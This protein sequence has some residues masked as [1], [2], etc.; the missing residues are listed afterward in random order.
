ML[1]AISLRARRPLW[2]AG[3][4]LL[5]LLLLTWAARG[6]WTQQAE[7][8]AAAQ[9]EAAA[10]EAMAY[11]HG[12]FERVQNALLVEAQAL[13]EDSAV[14]GGLRA[15]AAGNSVP[16]TLVRRAAT[17]PLL[18]RMAVEVYT[19]APQLVAWNGFSMPPDHAPDAPQFIKEPQTTI[20]RDGDV[21]L[22][23]V[24]WWP[25]RD[26][27]RTVGAVR[28][29]RLIR[30]RTSIQNQYLQDYRLADEWAQTTGLPVEMSLWAD[31]AAQLPNSAA[32]GTEA[33][34]ALRRVQLLEGVGGR[35]LGRLSVTA[36][37]TQQIV[38]QGRLWFS[39]LMALWATGGLVL[40]VV[41][42]WRRYRA[43]ERVPAAVPTDTSVHAHLRRAAVVFA[44]LA[45]AALG[46]RYA[47]LAM[48]VPA[49]WQSG[50]ALLAPLFDANHLAS[51]LAG[52][53][54]SSAGDLL[55][56]GG[57]AFLLA[58]AF[59]DLAARFRNKGAGLF[60]L[61]ERLAA[62][63]AEQPSLW[64]FGGVLAAALTV[65]LSLAVVPALTARRAVLD[66]TLDYLARTGLL[67]DPLVLAVFCGLLMITMAAVLFIAGVAWIAL[68][69][70]LRY[71]PGDRPAWMWG[72]VAAGAL[73]APLA[74]GYG[75]LGLDQLLNWPVAAA[76]LLVGGG[77][78]A[79]GF[80]RRGEGLE[81][82]T[83][84]CLLPAILL[85]TV[86]L[87]PML[88]HGMS[89]QR[90]D[91]MTDAAASFG[92]G[93][94]PRAHFSVQQVL[95]DAEADA[96]LAGALANAETDAARA[97]LDSLAA[98]LLR[99]SLLSSLDAYRASLTFFDSTGAPVGGYTA[100]LPSA[101]RAADRADLD[102]YGILRQMYADSRTVGPMV[103]PFTGRRDR[104]RFQYA[105]LT[106]VHRRGSS[107]PPAGWVMARAEPQ[108]L[109]S[110]A[111]TPF[112][113][114]LLPTG[115]Y[116]DLYASLSLAEFR[117]GALV[118]SLGRD[119]GR[120]RLAD[121]VR[122]ALVTQPALWRTE[123]VKGRAYLTYYRRQ[124]VPAP[125]APTVRMAQPATASV[126][127]VRVPAIT[128]FDHLYYILR[129]AVAGLCIG[130]PLYLV[131]LFV[132][133]QQGRLPAPQVRF[134]DKVL[135]AFLAVGTIS[136]VLVGLVGV[137]LLRGENERAT[138]DW[139]R[140]RLE[141]VEETLA[142]A[143]DGNELPY[144]TVQRLGL[145]VLAAR[146]GL[147]LNLYEGNRLIATS[148]PRLVR[149]QLIDGRL[150]VEAYEALYFDGYRFTTTRQEIGR[151]PYT[152]GF[153]A[154]PDEQGRPRLVLSAPTLPEQERIAEEQARATAYLFG[155]LLLLVVV[156]MFTASLLAGALARPI[157]R[158]RAGLEAVGRGRFAQR[159]PVDTRDEIGELVQT[160]NEMRDQLAES[161]RKLAQQERELAWR[162]MARQVAHEIKNPLT[163]MKLSVQHLRRAYERLEVPGA[164]VPV[165]PAS[166]EERSDDAGRFRTL[167]ERITGTLIEQIDALARIAN[168]F[169][170]FARLPTRVLEPLDLNVVL[171]EAVSLMQ[172]EAAAEIALDLHPEPLVVEADQEELRRIYINL[173]KNALQAIPEGR[174]G[175]VR[176]ATQV[177]GVNGAPHARSTVADN[178]SG[179]P[180]ELRD[181]I[182]QPNFSTKN[183]GTGLG[184]AICRKGVEEMGG[185]MGFETE[186]GAGTT[187][188]VRLPRVEE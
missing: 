29:L 21:R 59:L 75:A 115:Y 83:L 93:R 23:L 17:W 181:K 49:R 79:F 130:V 172:E 43:V 137:R 161:R 73:A 65:A 22:A 80:V 167:F 97:Q 5:A 171:R 25:V 146:S 103:E 147:D 126:T 127:A 12:R 105:G 26:G 110:D 101:R 140:Q 178:G 16:E 106:P 91:Q 173:I 15:V 39:D 57:F 11:A 168:E 138:Q 184:L 31:A 54:F 42:L 112:P 99:G 94:D 114:A 170:S 120:Y 169:H 187:F 70:L 177:E 76:V 131:G 50:A 108:Q 113:R 46:L 78:A 4:G 35:V 33:D 135:N 13:A 71:W 24:A 9:Q 116:G 89:T 61:R 74:L 51:T 133:W 67:P 92:D 53:L 174:Q 44:L 90:R 183:S 162:E 60:Q 77:I 148:R 118:R 125:A 34:H 156:V 145:D 14:V 109:A 121:D 123:A 48:D 122:E 88:Y 1:K 69:M 151:F 55:I 68:W 58:V 107:G 155:A 96:A 128:T 154:L 132:R 139:L 158:L 81:L 159:L 27:G 40:C 95:A 182:F 179:I 18:E 180:A 19:S 38:Q 186:E 7:Q 144:R 8:H 56:T 163:P 37:P 41:G 134:R 52:G 47:L 66:S 153:R 166:A 136:V 82:L 84:R 10:A 62:Q 119:F 111:G 142:M 72:L 157:A 124:E 185:E 98:G 28:T 149:E 104:D 188:W 164:A 3:A 129:L 2:I 64:R 63:E 176:V 102:D 152:A 160:F 141:Q 36:P 165:G 6:L 143:A 100:A 87:Y 86:V 150:P 117:G 175:L 85:V 45:V 32:G 20:V 30:F